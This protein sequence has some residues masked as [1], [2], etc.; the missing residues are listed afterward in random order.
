MIFTLPWTNWKF[1]YSLSRTINSPFSASRKTSLPGDQ[2]S[3]IHFSTRFSLPN[4]TLESSKT[5]LI[6]LL[7]PNSEFSYRLGGNANYRRQVG[8][9]NEVRYDANR[10]GVGPSVGFGYNYKELIDIN[11]RYSMD[12]VFSDFGVGNNREEEYINHTF[13]IEATTYWQKN[14]VFGNDFT[15][16]YFGNVAAAGFDPTAMLWNMSLGYQFL[17][18]NATL[19]IKVYDLLNENVSTSRITGQDFVQDTQELIL[20]QYF[21][22]SFT[23][24]LSKFGGKD[25]NQGGRRMMRF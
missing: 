7:Y 11:P 10:L 13:G 4:S 23:Y 12:Y 15:Y 18:D 9:T 20:E 5:I 2:L 17:K 22:L 3:R 14:I 19:K 1:I 25:P 16:N 6:S 24:K 21:M 8:F